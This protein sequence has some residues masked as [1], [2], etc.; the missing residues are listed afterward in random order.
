[1]K[2]LLLLL[3]LPLAAQTNYL[4]PEMAT[5]AYVSLLDA[6]M[7]AARRGWVDPQTS[8]SHYLHLS[9]KLI[10]VTL[11]TPLSDWERESMR[12]EARQLRARVAELEALLRAANTEVQ[13]LQ[14]QLKDR[15]PPQ[16]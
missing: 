11:Y 3:C 15:T 10:E 16:K 2:A 8:H 4:S 7:E 9:G 14:E 6:H 1:M 12:L 13:R 5:K